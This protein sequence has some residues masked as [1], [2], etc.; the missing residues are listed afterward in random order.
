MLLVII[1]Y[2]MYNVQNARY[3][4]VQSYK[5]QNPC[6][7]ICTKCS[8]TALKELRTCT[9]KSWIRSKLIILVGNLL[10]YYLPTYLQLLPTYSSIPGTVSM[11]LCELVFQSVKQ[12]KGAGG[13]EKWAAIKRLVR[14][15]RHIHLASFI[16]PASFISIDIPKV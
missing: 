10:G 3:N 12:K 8:I 15:P 5:V 14:R 11:K 13:A 1:L 7:N 4:L 6:Y 9:A 2:K 16:H